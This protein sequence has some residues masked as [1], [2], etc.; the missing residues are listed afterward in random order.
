MHPQ[1]GAQEVLAPQEHASGEKKLNYALLQEL[2][3]ARSS[4]SYPG[5]A[6]RSYKSYRKPQIP[7]RSYESYRKPQIPARSLQ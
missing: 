4:K 3:N 6:A 5:K 7:A 1:E 2:P